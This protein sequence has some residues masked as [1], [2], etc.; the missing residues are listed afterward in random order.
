MNKLQISQKRAE[1]TGYGQLIITDGMSYPPHTPT[2]E[3]AE[4][5]VSAGVDIL[6]CPVMISDVHV[7]WMMGGTEQLADVKNVE[8]EIGP[9]VCWDS[10]DALMERFPDMCIMAGA[11]PSDLVAY[12]VERFAD[13]CVKHGVAALDCPGYS[14][15][16]NAPHTAAARG[17]KALEER[18]IAMIQQISTGMALAREGT[19]EFDLFMKVMKASYGY[20]LMM[21]DAGGKSGA[22]GALDVEGV[23]PAVARVRQVMKEIDR[24]IPIIGVCG[25]ASPENAREVIEMG[26]DGAMISSAI[27]RRQLAGET[28]E[29]I[30]DYLR[31]MKEGL[32]K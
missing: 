28:L 8:M 20:V 27:I 4:M 16:L 30:G 15:V 24:E 14:Y 17:H 32:K 13:D 23:K 22:T 5:A 10:I 19:R 31:S 26:C 7:P 2:L 29:Q 1:E 11:F 9:R 21:M 12:G 18:G 3:Y 25:I 6:A